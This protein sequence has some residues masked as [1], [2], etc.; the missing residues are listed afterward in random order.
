MSEETMRAMMILLAAGCRGSAHGLPA[1]EG[2]SVLFFVG[3]ECPVSNFY[4]PEIERLGKGPLQAALV[5]SEL[6]LSEET[7]ERHASAYRLTLPRL[8]DADQSLARA[9]RVER[10]PTAVVL[11]R[12]DVLYRGRI[13]DRYTPE[14]KRR[15][16]VR[17]RDLESA[18]EAVL[19][20]RK[21]EVKE[22]PVFGCPLVLK[23]VSK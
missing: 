19:A 20:G 1:V 12:G 5:Y 9:C 16:D 6:G 23:E 22:T 21:P 8:V 17:S 14:G 15:P 3:P 10:I 4:A 18:I 2:P 7:L 11:R 13:D